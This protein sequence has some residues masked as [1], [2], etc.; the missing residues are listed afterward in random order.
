[1]LTLA[2]VTIFSSGYKRTVIKCQPI[3]KPY[4]YLQRDHIFRSD[5]LYSK[6]TLCKGCDE[7]VLFLNKP[8]VY[9]YTVFRLKQGKFPNADAQQVTSGFGQMGRN[10]YDGLC[11]SFSICSGRG[12][13]PGI[14]TINELLIINS[15]VVIMGR[16]NPPHLPKAVNRC[17]QLLAIVI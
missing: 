3:A 13:K 12:I 1:L 5:C 15:A 11:A 9:P 8:S 14:R 6:F 10:K 4:R 16:N 2:L 17:A 7:R